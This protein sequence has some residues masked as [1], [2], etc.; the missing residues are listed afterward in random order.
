MKPI[1]LYS[2]LLSVVY[3]LLFWLGN[4]DH[5]TESR[6]KDEVSPWLGEAPAGVESELIRAES[7]EDFP[8]IE[9]NIPADAAL[10]QNIISTF[11]LKE[12]TPGVY[13]NAGV[14]VI[15]PE[16]HEA[17]ERQ[18]YDIYPSLTVNQD[19]SMRLCVH[20]L[21]KHHES[22]TENLTAIQIPNPQ[23][24]PDEDSEMRR[25]L[26]LAVLCFLLP[27]AF[28]SIGWL[29]IQ[30]NPI[31]SRDTI[32]I[33]LWIPGVVAFIGAYA[34]FY[35]HGFNVDYTVYSA[36]FSVI[37]NLICSGLIIG[38]TAAFR[39]VWKTIID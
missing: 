20:N 5:D 31:R 25:S 7:I 29:W 36:T 21:N 1:A 30:R 8:Y 35:L 18:C 37:S 12:S 33:C 14:H 17:L 13:E 27:G 16:G 15:Y 23:Y 32:N 10:Q 6:W 39:G 11:Q 22:K 9:F 4:N 38:A 24:L 19:G 34:D 3:A 26:L 2:I 28:C